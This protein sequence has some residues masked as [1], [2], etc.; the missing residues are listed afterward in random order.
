MSTRLAPLPPSYTSPAYTCTLTSPPNCGLIAPWA[1]RRHQTYQIGDG[2]VRGKVNRAILETV[3]GEPLMALL[4]SSNRQRAVRNLLRS[5]REDSG[6]E[7]EA[8]GEDAMGL[9]GTDDTP[10]KLQVMTRSSATARL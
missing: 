5:E 10:G 7:K 3:F 4:G 8:P 2:L 6:E 9:I 1:Q